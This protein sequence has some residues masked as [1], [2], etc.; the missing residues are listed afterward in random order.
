MVGPKLTV[1]YNQSVVVTPIPSLSVPVMTKLFHLMGNT[2]NSTVNGSH[3]II[4]IYA[5]AA[6]K[7]KSS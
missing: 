6:W 7:A 5:E 2:Q 4:S 1:G 3:T